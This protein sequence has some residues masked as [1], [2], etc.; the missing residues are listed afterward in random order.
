MADPI[1]WTE[2][3]SSLRACR[4]KQPGVSTETCI[5][6]L[7]NLIGARQGGAS[8]VH[9]ID[10]SRL[11]IPVEHVLDSWTFDVTIPSGG[12]NEL[13]AI[14]RSYANIKSQSRAIEKEAE[15]LKNWHT[16]VVSWAGEKPDKDVLVE[17]LK[18]TIEQA[19]AAGLAV[20]LEQSTLLSLVDDFSRSAFKSSFDEI[21]RLH[22][23]KSK[24]AVLAILGANH[25]PAVQLAR[26]LERRVMIFLAGVQKSIDAKSLNLGAD[27]KAEAVGAL[28]AQVTEL[29]PVLK[30]IS[31]L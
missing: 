13:D 3:Q 1:S 19:K 10:V 20:G 28:R 22:T 11:R 8:K 5:D 29:V 6:H 15:A 21:E 16:G 31:E 12:S 27:P 2:F 18:T 4:I 24:G 14:K 7:L 9:A 26:E 30:E 23:T 25:Q 17:K